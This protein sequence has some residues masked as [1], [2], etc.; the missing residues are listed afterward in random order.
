MTKLTGREAIMLSVK[1][2]RPAW[3]AATEKES[4]S[5]GVGKNWHFGYSGQPVRSPGAPCV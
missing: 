5:S 3:N 4:Q 1:R 2:T